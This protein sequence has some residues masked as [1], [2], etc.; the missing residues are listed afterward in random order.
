MQDAES[1]TQIQQDAE[2]ITQIHIAQSVN[3]C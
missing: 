1:I 2:S 3:D